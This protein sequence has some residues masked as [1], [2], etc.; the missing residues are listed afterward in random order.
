M[1]TKLLRWY[2]LFREELV[3]KLNEIPGKQ[4]EV[5]EDYVEFIVF[6]SNLMYFR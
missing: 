1:E 5:L 6:D 3:W 2:C 4:W